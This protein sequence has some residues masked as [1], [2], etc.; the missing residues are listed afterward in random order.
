MR[1]GKDRF[2]GA[3]ELKVAKQY[4]LVDYTMPLYERLR[5][6]RQNCINEGNYTEEFNNLS[7]SVGL[8]ETRV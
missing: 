3:Y 2:L 1:Q 8:L 6:L 5:G 4:L 7:V